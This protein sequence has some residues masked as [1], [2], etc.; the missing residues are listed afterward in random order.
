VHFSLRGALGVACPV[1]FGSA[2]VVGAAALPASAQTYQDTAL[3]GSSVS[4]ATFGGSGIGAA[5]GNNV[6]KLSGSGVTWSL[7]GTVPA[8]VTLSGSTISFS[9]PIVQSP[10]PIVVDATDKNGN[11]EALEIPISLLP[12]DILLQGAAYTLVSLSGLTDSNASGDVKFN[13]TSSESGDTISFAESNLPAGLSSGSPALSYL[14]GTAAPGTYSGAVVTATDSDGAALKG[15]FDLTVEANA[16]N[17]SYG[18]EVNRFGNGFDAFRQHQYPGAI[19]A[20]WTATQGDRGTHF[21]LSKGTHQGAFRFEYAPQGSGSGLC[22]SDPGGGWSS[23][24]LRDGLILTPCNTGLWQQ[25]IPQSNG[26][27]K[28]VATGLYV[29]PNGAAAQL[30]GGSSPTQWGGSSYTWKDHSSLPG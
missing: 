22:V 11:A 2:L 10:N 29:N 13:A 21:I 16:V 17:S 24:P 3:I 26:A 19:I 6:I 28:N 18:D 30:R 25:F 9:G 27:L 5:D 7:H 8:G 23:D 20:G 12:H 1:L 14:G 15:T 4:D